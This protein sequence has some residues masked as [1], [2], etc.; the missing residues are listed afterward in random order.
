MRIAALD[1]HKYGHFEECQLRFEACPTDLHIVFGANEAGKSTTMAGIGDLL[2]GFG[3]VTPYDFRFDR[4][5]LRVGARL[6]AAGAGDAGIDVVYRR[7]KGR[8]GTLLDAEDKPVGDAVL[9]EMLGGY[10]IDSFRRMFSLDH[11]RLREGGHAILAA[12]DDIGQ[13]I[14]SAGSGLLGVSGLLDRLE[15]ESKEIWTTRRAGDRRYHVAH[16]RYEAARL[17]QKA[18][19]IKP[20]AWDELRLELARLDAALAVLRTRRAGLEREREDVERGR[21][22]LPHAAAYR[23][24]QAELAPLAGAPELPPGAAE[25]L[26]Q[27]TITLA[28]AD[29]EIAGATAER[30][31]LRL[32]LDELF[33]DLRL[34]AHGDAIEA[35]RENKGAVDKSLSDLPRRRAD[36]A[37]RTQRLHG[38]L[39]EMGWPEEAASLVKAR[40]PQRVRL[41]ELRGFLEARSALD[42][43]LSAAANDAAVLEPAL[44]RLRAGLAALPPAHDLAALNTALGLA[45]DAGDIETEIRHAAQEA[46]R[47]AKGLAACLAQLAPWTGT[48]DQLGALLLPA[49]GEMTA[50]LAQ[51]AQVEAALADA[52]RDHQ[53]EQ[54]RQSFLALQH[55]QLT[56]D[57][58]AV[59]PE[60]VLEARRDRDGLWQAMRAHLA[61][62]AYLPSPAAVIV[63]FERLSAAADGVADRRFIGA[64]QSGRLMA[65][66]EEIEHNALLRKQ[67]AQ[68]LRQAEA[69]VEA[70][71]A[72]WRKLLAPAELDMEPRAFSAWSDR[73]RRALDSADEAARMS[74]IAGDLEHRRETARLRL[75]EALGITA[76]T[77]GAGDIPG[78]A[79]LKQMAER[80]EGIEAETAQ[81]RRDIG[82]E[83]TTLEDASGRAGTRHRQALEEISG[84]QESWVHAVAA[85]GLAASASTAIVRAQLDLLETLRGEVDDIL[86]LEQRVSTMEADIAAFAVRV[87]VLAD[88]CGLAME[89]HEPSGHLVILATGA[90]EAAAAQMRHTALV[91]QLVACERR[92]VDANAAHNQAM[93]RLRP[94]SDLIGTADPVRLAMVVRQSDRVRSLRYEMDRLV[95]EILQ[96]GSGPTLETL[97]AQSRDDEASSL[98]ARHGAI[99]ETLTQVAEEITQLTGLRGAAHVAFAQL[100]GGADAAS[101]AFDAEQARAEMAVQAE[102]YMRKRA[103][104]ALLRWTIARYRAEKQ[105]PLLNRASALFRTLTLGRY[106][107]LLVDLDGDKAR[108]GGLSR[109][110]QTIVPVEGMSEG[111]VDQ[112]FL[113]LRLAAV[114]D[115]V[116]AGVRLPFIADDLFVNYD[117]ERARAGFQVLAELAR[118]TQVLFFTHHRHL[119]GV[120]AQ[121][122]SPLDVSICELA[123]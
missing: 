54:D 123:A 75:A 38:L 102:A 97:L 112:L 50:S 12:Q 87:G 60:Q 78:F 62:E 4:Q 52:T 37:T 63:D 118:T 107:E 8:T 104:V 59:S 13:A 27:I 45:R 46:A 33:V 99:Q 73:R 90:R 91:E 35:L 66:Q 3:H 101:A 40:L 122:L 80:L 49:D 26:N 18:A 110:R 117:D 10:S 34:L 53:L 17:Q 55:A 100:D 88:G 20:A 70:A 28:M 76:G 65:L 94:L 82:A 83:I 19:Q 47:W 32:A 98:G 67:Q 61:G 11:A 51:V 22:V 116:A 96:A 31:Q 21:R 95:T 108:L 2:F 58:N 74:S 109:D 121:A 113:A 39:A 41:A 42:A 14:F 24:A 64:Q 57:I 68:R 114:E 86:S 23:H 7:K 85:A 36:L 5:L 44:Q 120:A 69:A 48:A 79:I 56:R 15:A 29:A 84:W 43:T 93:A 30:E 6:Q 103:E 77:P 71:A 9:K 119:L 72:A 89:E 25:T 115:T 92:L 16:A 111:T 106:V 81:R 105:T 1:L